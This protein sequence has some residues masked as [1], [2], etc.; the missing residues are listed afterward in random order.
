MIGHQG[1]PPRLL[2]HYGALTN[3]TNLIRFSGV[4]ASRLKKAR[5]AALWLSFAGASAA[6][7]RIVATFRA[8]CST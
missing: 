4:P 3:S 8:I 5:R 6:F 7:I 1:Q 2:L